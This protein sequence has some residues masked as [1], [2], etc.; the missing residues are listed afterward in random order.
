MIKIGEV[1]KI[2]RFEEG[3]VKRV[4]DTDGTVAVALKDGVRVIVRQSW[5]KQDEEEKK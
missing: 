1:V 4:N 2:K 3:K 5:I